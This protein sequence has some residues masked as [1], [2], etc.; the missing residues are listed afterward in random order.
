M[1]IFKYTMDL[2][3]TRLNTPPHILGIDTTIDEIINKRRSIARFGD[4]EFDLLLRTNDIGFQKLNDELGN[5]LYEVLHSDNPNLLV[6][7]PKVFTSKDL[8]RMHYYARRCWVRLL[9]KKRRAIYK[10]LDFSKV[11]G[12]AFVT[13]NYIDLEDKSHVGEYFKKIK[14]IWDARDVVIIEGRY[15]RFGVGNDLLN[16]A[17]SVKRI[18]CPEKNAFEKYNEILE[19]SRSIDKNCLVLIAL[20]PT[21]TVMAYDLCKYS[22]QAIDIGHLDIEYEWYLA[23]VKDKVGI[24]NKWTNE[25]NS[26]VDNLTYSLDD[27]EYNDSI[28]AV[29][30]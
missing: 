9:Y 27:N 30:N 7:L 5:R 12:D 16:N 20:G 13:R 15:T 14:G 3:F 24:C 19:C 8:K 10:V 1:N 28:I 29:I 25:T 21:A 2:L 26:I 4:G 18:L 22:Y 17:K 23:G 11:Y 6:C